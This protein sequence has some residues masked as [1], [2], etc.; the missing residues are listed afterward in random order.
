[1]EYR[2]ENKIITEPIINILK[3]V[4]SELHNDNLY[5]MRVRG[6]NIR[7]PCPFHIGKDGGVEKHPSCDIYIGEDTDNLKYGTFHCFTCG[8]TGSLGKL[9]SECFNESDETFGDQWLIDNF[10]NIFV[11][12]YQN[13]PEINLEKKKKEYLDESILNEYNYYHPYMFKRKISQ[14]IL[15][16]FKIGYDKKKEMIVFPIWDEHNNL[17]MLSRRSVI[18][19][20]FEID[21]NKE[22]PIY[23][24]NYILNENIKNVYVVESQINA[25]TLWTWGYPAIALIGTGSEEQYKILNKSGITHYTLCFDGDLAGDNGCRKFI[26]NI[27]NDVLID[28]TQIPRTK[29]VNDLDKDTFD[30]LKI[31][32]QIDWLT[33]NKNVY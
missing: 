27:K 5:N 22:K 7:I 14:S 33:L 24:L 29:D 11:E 15:D 28:I 31:F 13:L 32:D 1:M 17:V 2:I 23:L 12:R 30:K 18:N 16:K 21:S 26:K 6:N 3:K 8:E 20:R 25:L 4:K 9:I 10:G 19:K